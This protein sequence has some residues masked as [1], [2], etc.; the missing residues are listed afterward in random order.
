MNGKNTI[1]M[2][3]PLSKCYLWSSGL[4]FYFIPEVTKITTIKNPEIRETFLLDPWISILA[5]LWPRRQRGDTDKKCACCTVLIRFLSRV[6]KSSTLSSGLPAFLWKHT[7]QHNRDLGQNS[8]ERY[9]V[10][11]VLLE[12][13]WQNMYSYDY[14]LLTHSFSSIHV[15]GLYK[16]I[17]LSLPHTEAEVQGGKNGVP[18]P[19]CRLGGGLRVQPKS[20]SQFMQ[21]NCGVSLIPNFLLPCL[22]LYLAESLTL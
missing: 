12:R 5:L 7:S 9:W 1:R 15:N 19:S 11:S 14:L 21:L 22:T 6:R 20:V 18:R 3:D 16:Y 2:T 17:S 10:N 13:K 4:L 8:R